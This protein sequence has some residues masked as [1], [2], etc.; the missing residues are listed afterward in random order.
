MGRFDHIEETGTKEVCVG[1]VT[2]CQDAYDKPLRVVTEEEVRQFLVY[3][4]TVV[5][6][7]KIKKESDQEIEPDQ[8]TKF[9]QE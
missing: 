8:E 1:Y 3:E 6:G 2:A 7:Y 9:N 4:E 5:T